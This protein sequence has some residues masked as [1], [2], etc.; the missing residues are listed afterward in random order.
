[1]R[2]YRARWLIQII[3]FLLLIYGGYV[4]LRFDNFLPQW[5]CPNQSN[6][7]DGCYLL[8][9][10]RFQYGLKIDPQDNSG[11][12]FPGY[13]V[14][15]GLT[16]TYLRFFLSLIIFIIIFNKLWCGWFCPFGTFQDLINFIAKKFVIKKIQFSGKIRYVLRSIKYIF[17]VIFFSALVILAFGF[18]I[19]DSPFFCKFCPAKLF[20]N[21]FE[22]NFLNLAVHFSSGALFSIITCIL[23]GIILGGVIFKKRLFCFFC[24]IGAFINIFNTFGFL[25]LKK[26]VV[27]CISCKNCADICPMDIKEVYLEKERSDVLQDDCI[28]CLKCIESC[29]QDKTLS[30]SCFKKNILS[31]SKNFRLK[32]FKKRNIHS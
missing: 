7:F 9:L 11:L 22:G 4:G 19:E 21:A 32:Y 5:R 25:K 27:S 30:I 26:N 15:W 6:Y 20:L 17:L 31:S 8:P 16:K 18:N 2:I 23:S 29:P 24:P 3:S 28:L 1:M 12:H 10:Q 14:M 13:V